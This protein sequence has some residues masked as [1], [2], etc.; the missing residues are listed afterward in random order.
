MSDP[1]ADRPVEQAL[2]AWMHDAAPSQAPATLLEDTYAETMKS[3]QAR[4]YPWHRVV[5]GGR[6]SLA[7]SPAFALL[8]V[9]ALVALAL[10]VLLATGGIRLSP[11][12][13]PSP[14][15]RSTPSPEATVVARSTALPAAIPIV[16]EASVPV[17][18][19]LALAS[20]ETSIW[21]LAGGRID[22]VD[23]VSNR[24]SGSVDIGLASDLYNGIAVNAAGVWA[25]D[26][27]TPTLI[28]IDKITLEVAARIEAG[29]APKG[30]LANAGGVWVADVHGGAV[31]RIDPESNLPVASV[32]VGPT[33][34]SGPNWLATGLDSV[35]V[36]IPNNGTIAR[37]DPATDA[38]QAVI[39]APV[40]FT[41][42]GGIAV[43]ADAAW[44]TACAGA[45]TVAR[46]DPASNTSATTI[47]LP[48]F[49]FNPTLIDGAPWVS[50]DNGNAR[51]GLLVRIDPATN[52]IDR[53]LKP[54]APFGGG[55]DIV[56]AAGSVWVMDG[57]NN[58][59]LR[60]PLAAFEDR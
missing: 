50:I 1:R 40:G 43:G 39:D 52:T 54:E 46:I 27:T 8:V 17:S 35:W 42:C 37:I 31:L 13:T 51:S 59:L 9:G 18:G 41:P 19:A 6:S 15:A 11:P 45:G 29:A 26:S 30:V 10:S 36:G 49:A 24:V 47:G 58:V 12:A 21:V 20:D 56:V 2:T 48:G 55:G 33:G 28:R 44:I 57:Y 32:S 38:I 7:G 4:A 14:T 53:V 23:L 16:A 3:G 34:N 60:L 25:T 5:V 22:Q